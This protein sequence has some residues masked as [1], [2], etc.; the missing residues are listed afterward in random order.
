DPLDWVL[1]SLGVVDEL[2]VALASR[3]GATE[4]PVL[5]ISLLRARAAHLNVLV[6][7]VAHSAATATA[8]GADAIIMTAQ[9]QLGPTDPARRHPLLPRPEGSTEP[10]TLSVQDLRRSMEFVKREIGEDATPE[11][12]GQVIRALF[13]KVHPMAIGAIEQ[14]YELAKQVARN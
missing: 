9:A 5:I 2:D 3:G 8:L 12:M 13:D 11:I 4:L 6:A 10:I 14:S 1:E 7:G